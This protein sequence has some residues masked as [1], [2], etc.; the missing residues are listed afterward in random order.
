MK[1]IINGIYFFNIFFLADRL[2]LRDIPYAIYDD[3]I[4]I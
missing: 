4:C 2:Q 3:L 1:A